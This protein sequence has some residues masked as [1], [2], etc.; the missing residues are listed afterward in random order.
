[1]EF[2]WEIKNWVSGNKAKFFGGCEY[3][4]VYA[5]LNF[6]LARAPAS[7]FLSIQHNTPRTAL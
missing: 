4:Y 7:R 5:T 6:E 2:H 1:M 3:D